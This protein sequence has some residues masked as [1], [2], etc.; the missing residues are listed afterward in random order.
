M[1]KKKAETI[2]LLDTNN[3]K[4][5]AKAYIFSSQKEILFYKQC[6]MTAYIYFLTIFIVL[7]ILNDF[8]NKNNIC[9]GKN[10]KSA[11]N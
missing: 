3:T 2:F 5:V 4:F 8:S 6:K 1:Q 7:N 11:I 9:F 10:T